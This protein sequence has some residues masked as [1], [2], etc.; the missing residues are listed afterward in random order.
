[1]IL[2]AGLFILIGILIKN[3]KFY[4]LIAGYNTMEPEK[5]ALYDIDKIAT[6]FRNVFFAMAIL[7]AIG[8]ALTVY[9]QDNTFET[10][11]FYSA[12][13]IGIPYLLIKSNSKSY[14]L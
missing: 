10:L 4:N 9:T 8:Y 3:F 14:K 6:L 11:T 13:I 1:M 7:I 2:T 12:L 5:K